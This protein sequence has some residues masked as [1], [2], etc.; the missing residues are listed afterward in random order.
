MAVNYLISY[1][2]IRDFI[3]KPISASIFLKGVFCVLIT[4]QSLTIK[5]Q[6]QLTWDQ[7]SIVR[8]QSNTSG[9]I[10][11][12]GCVQLT[13]SATDMNKT[14]TFWSKTQVDLSKSF[15][16]NFDMFFGC[17]DSLGAD[18]MVFV[19]QTA[20]SKPIGGGGGNLG[21]WSITPSVGVE[22]DTY[23]G[24]PGYPDYYMKFDHSDIMLN[25][26]LDSTGD[27]YNGRQT[28][29]VPIGTDPLHGADGNVEDCIQYPYNITWN[30][31]TMTLTL[32][33]RAMTMNSIY[34]APIKIVSY[35]GDL[36]SNT[37]GTNM[38]YWG[39]TG[40]TGGLAN[41]QWVCP[42]KNLANW[43]C[44]DS[45]CCARYD[46]EVIPNTDS[47]MCTNNL[48]LGVSGNYVKY[49]WSTG[50]TTST[51]TV[52]K[53][54]K[55]TLNVIRNKNGYLCPGSTTINVTTKGPT[56]SLSGDAA[57]CNN[58]TGTSPISVA[59]TGT[60]PWTI[61]YSKDGVTQP[62]VF[63]ITT[64]SYTFNGGLGVYTLVSVSD[65]SVCNGVVSG[66]ATI[67]AFPDLP[68]GKDGKFCPTSPAILSVTNNGGTYNWYDAPTGGN[69]LYTGA[70]YTTPPLTTEQ[71]YYVENLDNT[72]LKKKSVGYLSTSDPAST[73]NPGPGEGYN[74][75]SFTANKDFKITSIDVVVKDLGGCAGSSIK[76]T[77]TDL[78]VPQPPTT[79]TYSNSC[80]GGTHTILAVPCNF[81]ITS[82][83]NYTLAFD[84]NGNMVPIYYW[85]LSRGYPITKDA[86]I[87]FT[88]ATPTNQSTVYP[89]LFN[90]QI[91]YYSPAKSCARTPIKAVAS[92][93]TASV[94]DT[95]LLCNINN[96]GAL[97]AIPGAG[98]VPFTYLWSNNKT[99]ATITGLSPGAYTVT[100][101][102]STGCSTKA[103]GNVNM[104]TAIVADA[105]A[106]VIICNGKNTTLTASGS[107]N[108]SW[109]TAETTAQITVHPTVTTTYTVTVSDVN[110]CS[111]SDNV[112]V[113]VMDNCKLTT[114]LTATPNSI[115]LGDT[116]IVALKV[117][118]LKPYTLTWS[119]PTVTLTGDGSFKISPTTNVTYTVTATENDDVT[120]SNTSSVVIVVNPLPTVTLTGGT[121]CLGTPITMTAGGANTYTWSNGL[122]GGTSNTVNPSISTTY[123]VTGMDVNLCTNTAQAVV[124]INQLP[125]VVAGGG[126]ICSG[127]SMNITAGGANTYK[128]SNGAG[129]SSSVS[130]NPTVSTTYI[131]T[132]T[133]TQNCTNT[134]QAII[135][136]KEQPQA[137]F[138]YDPLSILPNIT[139]VNFHDAT[140]TNKSAINKW[141][142]ISS[143]TSAILS[144]KDIS[145]MFKNSGTYS[146]KLIVENTEGCKDSVLKNINVFEAVVVP[147][148][149]TPNNDGVNDYFKIK[150]I[151][152]GVWKLL[153]YNRWGRKVYENNHYDNS[154]GADGC[155]DGVYY[156][157]LKGETDSKQIFTGY[158]EVIR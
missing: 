141:S 11:P 58:G 19:L 82:G 73:Q 94:K 151:D 139:I 47:V 81:S 120:I 50:D 53:P 89:G 2:K 72:L 4:L 31:T 29:M 123:T 54:G 14:S 34:Q 78:T 41:E 65:A 67:T 107:T 122:P 100:V 132:G 125:T 154:W 138:N 105:G 9:K 93:V 137:A 91:E 26:G 62:A 68:Q 59:L 71:T 83:H 97:T 6:V 124:T 45:S 121:L 104:P 111:A 22:F 16:I 66:T 27:P 143:D 35:T 108:F 44:K 18:G 85:Y 102:D 144:G 21:Y 20:S 153:I 152:F 76:L 149:I 146:V 28:E 130:V 8:N 133:D 112:V 90:W 13:S 145:H 131:V 95:T 37:F 24:G 126:A 116:T 32:T 30:A 92:V 114:I 25:G 87:T 110:N 60:S 99:T 12:N 69:L 10:D 5:A 61:Q 80:S 70:T 101:T 155:G 57:I 140:I 43:V 15:S 7:N 103:T 77:L 119:T 63:G 36:I 48:T 51:T 52:R 86:E 118:S 46:K 115:C 148:V 136:V 1:L 96:N 127:T 64:S 17:L 42:E 128:W 33:Q 106:D 88:G 113:T 98:V 158:V 157:I 129:N 84:H 147:N 142:W 49:N 23:W 117:L 79:V 39:F 56:A 109:S 3:M 74:T 75:I 135:T 55:Y 40:A 150:G 156:Y 38:V 134:A